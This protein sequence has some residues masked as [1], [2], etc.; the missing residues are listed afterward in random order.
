MKNPAYQKLWPIVAAV[1]LFLFI[2]VAYFH[3]LFEGKSLF[4][5]DISHFKGMSKELA[6]Y[7]ASTGKEALWDQFNVWWHACLSDFD[8]P[9]RQ[10][11]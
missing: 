10:P 7:R 9:Q 1:V 5:S 3:P 8:C 4:Q 6:D 11:E 2:T